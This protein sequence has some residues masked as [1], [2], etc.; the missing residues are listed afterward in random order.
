MQQI[1]LICVGKLKESFYADASKEYLKR[2]S[3]FCKIEID[4]VPEARLPDNPSPAEID[5]ALKVE[6]DAIA[7]RI[8]KGSAVIALCIEGTETDSRGFADRLGQLAV[9]GA[10]RLCFVIGGS[11]G[12][13][14][15]VKAGAKLLLSMSRM[16]FPHHLARIMLLEQVYRGFMI[17]GGGKYHK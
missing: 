9:G 3:A 12:L 4:E 14:P 11:N 6:A 5:A 16:T 8:T 15:E 1:K 10:S 7:G 2:L 13:H 17:L